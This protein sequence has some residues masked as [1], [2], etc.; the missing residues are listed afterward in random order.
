MLSLKGR[1]SWS[2]TLSLVLL[3]SLQWL[4]V[5]Y[6]INKLNE[7]QLIKRL[8]YEGESLLA[9]IQFNAS[10]QLEIDA[11]RLSAIYQRPFS[12]HYYVVISGQQRLVSRSLWDTD[13]P[14][15]N[16]ERDQQAI[17]HSNGPESQSL[18]IVSNGYQ[19]QGQ[20]ISIAIA[21]N[22]DPLK[23]SIKRFQIMYAA[24]S[25]FGLILLLAIQRWIIQCALLPLKKIQNDIAKLER[26]EISQ[27][28]TQGP[29]EIA[30][31]INELNH[32]L[33]SIQQKSKRSRESLGNLAHALKTKLTLL[34]QTAE[35]PEMCTLPEIRETI[36]AA[37]DC[38]DDIIQRELKRARLMGDV[39]P[40]QQIDLKTEIAQLTHTMRMIYKEKIVNIS[41]EVAEETK[42]YGDG[43]DLLEILGNLLDNACKWCKRNVSLTVTGSDAPIFVVEDD[44][45]GCPTH[46]L[47]SL[48]QRGF[49]ADENVAGSGLGL[50]I[51]YDIANGYEANL[52][53][54]RSAALGGLR[55]EVR[56]PPR[57]R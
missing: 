25:L 28:S 34:N 31:L 19:K 56:F 51:V 10:N 7:D 44:G 27:L 52:N 13:I 33:Q 45:P 3:I 36:Y 16:L 35:R 2:L 15:D 37:T 26:G 40:M 12:G 17:H 38:L 46:E 49:R 11:K 30:P 9:G 54:S 1:L 21:E 50:A 47:N 22:L 32:L 24:I 53:F 55:A 42:F 14:I 8:Q 6:A 4:V 20:L 18:L 39:R 29:E 23:A 48:T 43:E 41:W 5:T 57:K